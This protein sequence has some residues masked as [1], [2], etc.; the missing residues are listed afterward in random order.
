[1]GSVAISLWQNESMDLGHSEQSQLC[2]GRQKVSTPK[3][4]VVAQGA[5]RHKALL[6]DTGVKLHVW[7]NMFNSIL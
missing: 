1:M 7:T 5:Q 2:K 4:S 3:D 6:S